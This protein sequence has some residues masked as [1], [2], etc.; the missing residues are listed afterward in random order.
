MRTCA[1][2]K[3]LSYPED[4]CKWH[5]CT[6][7]PVLLPVVMSVHTARPINIQETDPAR[8]VT[9][10]PT[11]EARNPQEPPDDAATGQ[12]AGKNRH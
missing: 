9:N 3:Y 8:L 12:P 7:A 6:Y 10:C 1:D 11:W 5:Y 4:N 2:C